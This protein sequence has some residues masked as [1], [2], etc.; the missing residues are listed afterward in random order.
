[1]RPPRNQPCGSARAQMT[2]AGEGARA[3]VSYSERDRL[4]AQRAV[5]AQRSRSVHLRPRSAWPLSV[6]SREFQ[7]ADAFQRPP[8]TPTLASGS[9]RST[10]ATSADCWRKS[11]DLMSRITLSDRFISSLSRESADWASDPHHNPRAGLGR[12]R[13]QLAGGDAAMRHVHP[14]MGIGAAGRASRCFWVCPSPASSKSPVIQLTLVA[15]SGKHSGTT[16]RCRHGG[17]LDSLR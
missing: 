8:A 15:F 12:L 2:M 10:S 16:V 13:Q 11:P 1:M 7:D 4:R 6:L 3:F 9:I 17:R 14:C 5:S